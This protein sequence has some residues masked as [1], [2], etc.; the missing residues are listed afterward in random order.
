MDTRMGYAGGAR[1]VG[2][3][4]WPAYLCFIIF[5]ILM[6]FSR[7]QFK[8]ITLIYSLIVAII[9]G[10]LAV[11]LLII[12]FNSGNAA[13]RQAKGGFAREAVGTGMLFMIPFTVLAVLALALL[14]WNAVMPF[15]SSAIT[16]AAATAGSEAMKRGAQGMKNVMIPTLVAMVLSTAWMMLTGILP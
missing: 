9:V 12:A 3:K 2:V 10:V 7:P 14:G 6:P 5:G 11:N 8:F 1:P 4:L 13:L 16:T 15:A